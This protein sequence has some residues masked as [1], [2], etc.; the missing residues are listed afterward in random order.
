MAGTPYWS[1]ATRGLDMSVLEALQLLLEVL[2]L[3]V[4]QHPDQRLDGNLE[5]LAPYT[6]EGLGGGAFQQ[7]PGVIELRMVLGAVSIDSTAVV[8][9][10]DVDVSILHQERKKHGFLVARGLE[11]RHEHVLSR[12]LDPLSHWS[13]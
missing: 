5:P 9:E 2:Q 3:D 4:F 7:L 6:Q 1:S 8:L 11:L 13:S 10:F 12:V